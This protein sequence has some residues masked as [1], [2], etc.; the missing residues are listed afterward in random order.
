MV[1]GREVENGHF[2]QNRGSGELGIML[3][4]ALHTAIVLEF[5][6]LLERN[7]LFR[8]RYYTVG[9]ENGLREKTH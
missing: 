1:E 3:R 4:L 5:L 9:E 8:L 2:N 6:S 7:K